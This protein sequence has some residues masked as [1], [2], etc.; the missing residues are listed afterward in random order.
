MSIIRTH[1]ADFSRAK[2]S[3]ME[4]PTHTL[5]TLKVASTSKPL[6]FQ[7]KRQ[8]QEHF[9]APTALEA[10]NNG[11]G[12]LDP[13]KATSGAT[14]RVKY[15][16]MLTSDTLVVTWNGVN[17]AD[18]WKSESE[19]G[20]TSGHVDFTVPVSVVA[21]SQGKN[22]QVV[23]AVVRN[24]Q[25]DKLSLPLE[26]SVTVLSADQLT[27]PHVPQAKDGVLDLNTFDGDASITVFNANGKYVWPLWDQGQT[28]WIVLEGIQQDGK[29]YKYYLANPE[30]LKEAEGTAGLNVK[31][32]RMEFEKLKPDSTLT[33]T[34]KV[35]FAK[36]SLES[37]AREF[38][39]TTYKLNT[40]LKGH[41]DFSGRKEGERFNDNQKTKLPSGLTIYPVI[42]N[43]APS[44]QARIISSGAQT[45]AL[46]YFESS[47]TYPNNSN[48]RYELEIGATGLPLSAQLQIT[49]QLTVVNSTN[50]FFEF[51]CSWRR[52]GVYEEHL[53]KY[54]KNTRE[55][56]FTVPSGATPFFQITMKAHPT[57]QYPG[58]TTFKLHKV[59]WQSKL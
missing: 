18:S 37:E 52:S 26:L 24:G 57:T 14:V 22:I 12:P 31:L 3:A 35:G 42:L 45:Q 7:V 55:I 38:P 46:E 58:S 19:N 56:T 48:V 15:D 39:I 27:A 50:S 10:A 33:V 32:P 30:W 11:N 36:G 16:G 53:Q 59:S 51:N 54:P 13:I 21:A 6:T 44:P 20:S 34:L 28:Y 29:N 4:H 49:V 41:E 5:A 1:S 47:I 17:Q 9:V 43:Q 23:Y 8:A 2:D 25:P 40:G